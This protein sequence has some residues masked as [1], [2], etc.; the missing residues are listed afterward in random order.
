MRLAV[1]LPVRNGE[2]LLPGWLDAVRPFADE[3]IALDDGS[4]DRTRE[5]LQADPLVSRLLSEPVRRGYAGWDDRRNR[6]RLLDTAASSGVDWVL[7]LDADERIAPGDGVA[8]REIVETL[9]RPGFAYGLRIH[10]ASDDLSEIDPDGRWVYRM[11]APVGDMELPERT[12]HLVPVPVSIPRRRWL[13]TSV[14]ILHVATTEPGD[15]EARFAKYLEADPGREWQASYDHLRVPPA[16]LDPV[17]P[18]QGAVVLPIHDR[19][20]EADHPAISAIVISRGDEPGLLESVTSVVDQDV[21]GGH[22]VIVVTSDS[23]EAPRRV[24]DAFPDVTVVA[25]ENPALPGA[26]RN[27]GLAVSRGDL[28]AFPSS[29]IVLPPGALAARVEAHHDGWAMVT[30]TVL[31]GT[32]TRSGWASYFLDHSSLLPGRPSGELDHAPTRCSYVRF[33]L[34]EVGGFPEDRRAGEDTVVNTE[35]W[36]RGFSAYREQRAGAIHR[37]PCTTVLRLV[38]HH[39]AR[40]RAWGQILLERHGSRRGVIMRRG[41]PLLVYVPRRIR[42]IGGAVGAHG[43]DL[44]SRYRR[45]WPLVA[46]GATAAWW[47]IIVEIATAAHRRRHVTVEPS[48]GEA[49]GSTRA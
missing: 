33:L 16:R 1:L 5:T 21:P 32:P 28:V 12:L 45:V 15:L 37:S 6:Q 47:G 26:A 43:G 24:R 13:R 27:A 10:A 11:F 8:I 39:R 3:V 14:R 49:V 18:R 29:H 20:D 48:L 7:W 4:T 17:P 36:R 2:R 40:G 35:L 46:L 44:R 22:E 42:R 38:R 23:D 9:G 30:G 34:D 25:L 31:N 19:A 41:L